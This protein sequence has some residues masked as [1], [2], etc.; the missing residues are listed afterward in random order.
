[1][2]HDTAYVSISYETRYLCQNDDDRDTHD[3]ILSMVQYYKTLL[4]Y[5]WMILRIDWI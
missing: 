4:N 1:M 5:Y 3:P 2:L